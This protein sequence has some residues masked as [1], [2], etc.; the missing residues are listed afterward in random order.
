MEIFGTAH[1][2]YYYSLQEGE[3]EP[4]VNNFTSP[5]SFAYNHLGQLVQVI[6]AAGTRTLGYNNF[7]EQETD[8]LLADGVTHLITE[9]RDEFGRSVGY[10]YAKNGVVQ[11]PSAPAM[12][13]MGVLPPQ[14]LCMAVR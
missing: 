5:C 10:T 13:M 11:R 1:S 14:A 8:S 7:G 9:L 4:V 12:A 6:D 3:T 2:T